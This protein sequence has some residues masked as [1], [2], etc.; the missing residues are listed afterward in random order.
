VK[1][2]NIDLRMILLKSWIIY[3][4]KDDVHDTP[5]QMTDDRLRRKKQEMKKENVSMLK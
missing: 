5:L 3:T 2:G 4:S 1:N